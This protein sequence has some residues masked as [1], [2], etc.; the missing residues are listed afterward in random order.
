MQSTATAQIYSE[1]F[2]IGIV[3]NYSQLK[4]QKIGIWWLKNSERKL[5]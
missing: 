2:Q 3:S 5:T 4:L 1:M